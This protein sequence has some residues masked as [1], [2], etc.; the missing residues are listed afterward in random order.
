M[1]VLN[2]GFNVDADPRRR[3]DSGARHVRR[4][5]RHRD[6]EPVVSGYGDVAAVHAAGW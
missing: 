1:T 6:R 2:I 4:R 3:A 5:A